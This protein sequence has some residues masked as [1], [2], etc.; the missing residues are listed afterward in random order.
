MRGL[1]AKFEEG[2]KAGDV[3]RGVDERE[4]EVEGLRKLEEGVSE[5]EDVYL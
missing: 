5:F 2:G 3:V 4:A 1:G